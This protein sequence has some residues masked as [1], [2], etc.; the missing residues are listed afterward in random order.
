[1]GMTFDEKHMTMYFTLDAPESGIPTENVMPTKNTKYVTL[2][3][4][5]EPWWEP[6]REKLIQTNYETF[7]SLPREHVTKLNEVIERAIKNGWSVQSLAKD[8]EK[9]DEH[10]T[11]KRAFA[12]A[13][14]QI[15]KLNGA[16]T[17]ARME[18]IRLKYYRWRT[19]KDERVRGNPNGILP[20]VSVSHYVMEGLMC[21][22]DDPTLCSYDLGKSWVTRPPKAPFLY[23]G[24][25]YR[26]RCIGVC[27]DQEL[28]GEIVDV[29]NPPS[30]G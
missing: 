30:D 15:G 20:D 29:L 23:P 28:F 13:H 4:F 16:I 5:D 14:D 18:K 19:C 7:R 11:K 26:C 27:I 25:D 6:L 12:F 9:I 3:M 17:K 8:I 21:R 24:Q 10:F 1:M 2:S 22:W